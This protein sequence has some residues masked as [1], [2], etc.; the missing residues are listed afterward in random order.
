MT[1]AAGP[2]AGG[3]GGVDVLEEVDVRAQGTA[4]AARRQ[5]VDAGREHAEE[6]AAVEGGI[7]GDDAL[8]HLVAAEVQVLDGG[9]R[10][11][12]I[13][14]WLKSSLPQDSRR[15]DAFAVIGPMARSERCV[16]TA[17]MEFRR[18]KIVATIGPASDDVRT[19][20]ALLEAG[21]DVVRLN[22]SHGT[23]IEKA[24][25]IAE[26]REIESGLGRPVAILADIQGPKI[27]VGL[28]P[29]S[30]ACG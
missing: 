1:A 27:R 21:V 29:G 6:E 18:T 4:G 15:P 5:A 3:A 28:I 17:S 14:S 11:V 22:F 26:I 9:L 16:D 7:V 8:V 23:N 2:Q 24:R 25:Q 10:V 12:I 13:R 20:R 19:L 30:A